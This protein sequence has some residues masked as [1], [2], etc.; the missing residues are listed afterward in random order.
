MGVVY[1]AR[2]VAL[3]R[4][5]ALK[6]IR[7][8]RF[9]SDAELLRFQNEAE[10]VAQLD[11]PQI[12]PIYEVGQHQ[13]HPFFSMKLIRGTGLDKRLEDFATDLRS[14]ARLV[15][16]VAEAI[17]HAH[18]RGIL[19]RDLKPANILLDEAGMP[20]V[21]DF[22]LAKR[23]DGDLDLT[24]SNALIGTPSYMSPEQATKARGALS[25]AT[26]VYGLGTILYALLT[27]RAPF[28]GTTLVE[29]LDMVRS[30]SPDPPS[31][32]NPRVPRDLEV[33]CQKC[34]EKEPGRRYAS[35][36]ELAEDLVRWQN[37]EPIR[38]R[39]VNAMVRAGMWCRRNPALAAAATLLLLV[40]AGGLAG[41]AWQ[42]RQTQRQLQRAEAVNELVTHRL[43]AFASPDLDP[44]A[45]ERT[46][47]ELL[48]RAGAQLGGWLDGQPEVEAIL[49]ETIG[50]AYLALGQYEPAEK[51]LGE[52]LRLDNR[53]QG[54]NHRDTLRATN[55]WA[56][57][58]DR[59]ERGTLAEPLLRRNLEQCR[60]A[61]G[62]DDPITLEAAERLA[63]LL[64]HLGQLDEAEALLRKNVDDRRRVLKPEHD[65]T[66][67]SVYLL[68]RLLRHRK[69]FAEAETLAYLY[70]HSIQC[71]RGTNHPDL[72]AAL[73][74]QGDVLRDQGKLA[75]AERYYQQAAVEAD[76]LGLRRPASGGEPAGQPLP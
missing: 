6:L 36:R 25:T 72:I 37:G 71:A 12:V 11:H 64:G 41:V 46:V 60:R 70:A 15:A 21:T 31:R 16:L 22:G 59:T 65:D 23:L 14:A 68:S 26:D 74:N 69:A 63:T 7:S 29:T 2:Q 50:G 27:G 1:E 33:I 66:L 62:P 58:L 44:R 17:H 34:L 55:L 53:L 48:D 57:L 9:A 67:R 4:A 43:L 40:L 73:T 76:R 5:V 52:A 19:H 28:A 8:G 13:G 49:R 24:H 56:T 20:H 10:A 47:R 54:P 32:L 30:Q 39:P 75:E 45:D 18:Q 3:G 38:A 42:W 35:A 61:L 51:H